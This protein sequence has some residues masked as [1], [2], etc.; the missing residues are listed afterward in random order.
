[1]TSPGRDFSAGGDGMQAVSA[2]G[3]PVTGGRF[4]V[5]NARTSSAVMRHFVRSRPIGVAKRAGNPG[6]EGSDSPYHEHWP[7]VQEISMAV[8]RSF[9][10]L[11]GLVAVVAAAPS[12]QSKRPMSFVDVLEMPLI[13]EP[14]LSPDGKYVAYVMF[15]SDWRAN[16]PVAHLYRVNADGTG[17]VQLTFGE[18]GESTPRWSPAGTTLAFLARRDNDANNQIYLLDV[19]GGEARRL[20]THATAPVAMQWAPD[21]QS[22]YFV[23]ADARNAEERARDRLQD[24]VYVFEENYKQRHLWVIDLAGRSRRITEGDWSVLGFEVSAD[25]RKIAMT[26]APSPLLEHNTQAEVWVMNSD[27]G[28]ARRLTTNDVLESDV[29]LSPDNST[30]VFR[31]GMNALFEPYYTEKIFVVAAS[32]GAPRLLLPQLGHEVQDVQWNEDG[33][34]LYF[35][36][37]MGV[38]SEVMTTSVDK[39]EA[40]PLTFDDHAIAGWSYSAP[41]KTHVFLRNTPVRANEIYTL[42]GDGTEE[43]RRVTNV[44]DYID[45]EFLLARQQ[46]LAWKGQDGREVEGLLYYPVD[47]VRGRRSPLIV[48]SHGGPEESD[49][50]GF[51]S[52]AQVYAG[53]GYAVLRPNYRGSTGYGDDFLRGMVGGYFTQAHLDVLAGVDAVIA[54]GIADPDRLVTMG[55]SAGGHMTNKLITFTDRFK[56]ASSFAG[57]ANWISMYAQSD[58]RAR[59]DLWFGGTPYDEQAALAG[60]WAHSP[61]KDVAKVK[62]P[63]LFIVGE[64]DARVPLAQSIEMYRGLKRHNVPTRLYVGPR[65]GHG[66][67]ELR[68]R[69]FKFQVEMEWF[70]RHVHQREY[71]WEIPPDDAGREPVR[72]S[73]PQP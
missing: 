44:F 15:R 48:I 45:R 5:M 53:K 38:H 55:S 32:G 6:R 26:R 41:A 71:T 27:A 52:D 34:S 7:P 54:M 49:K 51:S 13:Q 36:A 10:V 57:A 47:Y 67:G 1:M 46:R 58:T 30:V 16:R 18:R 29:S 12:A 59:R 17:Q 40:T 56:A 8:G 11:A 3:P 2:A 33:R 35:L 24:D 70:E 42:R 23:A 68:H 66:F 14:Q 19:L 22:I 73:T 20:T 37:N 60:Y 25:G 63:T 39:P 72:T 21:G 69:L 28:E 65:E 50:H 31:A 9:L 4:P 43:P 64:N 61:L 62:T